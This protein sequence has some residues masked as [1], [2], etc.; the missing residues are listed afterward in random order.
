MYD[1]VC[2][3]V[4]LLTLAINKKK[5]W[6][7]IIHILGKCWRTIGK[8]LAHYWENISE[9]L[10]TSWVQYFQK[11]YWQILYLERNIDTILPI[12]SEE[13]LAQYYFYFNRNIRNISDIH[14]AEI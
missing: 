5:Y 12:F 3:F 8:I 14:L 13:I 9:I 4:W 6:R 1:A 2:N 7:D 10:P 11:K